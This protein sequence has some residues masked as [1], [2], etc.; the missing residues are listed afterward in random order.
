MIGLRHGTVELADHDPEWEHIAAET[1]H[2]LSRVLGS[3]AKDIQHVGSTAI[4][5]IKAKPIIDIAVAAEDF[6]EVEA[7]TPALEA[8]GFVYRKKEF[9]DTQLLYAC[10]DYS[11]PDG[12]VTR[13]IHVV[14]VDSREWSNY[15]NFRDYMNAHPEDARKYE[16]LKIRLAAENPIDS[17]REKYLAGKHDFIVEMLRIARIWN[18]FG[19]KFTKIEPLNKGWSS[20]KKYYIET[21][22]DERLLLRIADAKHCNVRQTNFEAMRRCF[23]AGVSMQE[24]LDFGECNGGKSVYTLLSYLDGEDAST[25]L[26]LLPEAEQYAMGLQAGE[27]LLKIHSI[28]APTDLEPWNVRFER[29]KLADRL[30]RFSQIP[31]KP[32]N[33]DVVLRYIAKNQHL[34]NGRPQTQCHND[35]DETNLIISPDG[36]IGAIDFGCGDGG[37]GDPWREFVSLRRGTSSNAVFHT[38]RVK[39]YF[40]GEPPV[41]FWQILSLYF[42]YDVI[43][44]ICNTYQYD[45]QGREDGLRHW[46]NVLSWYDNFNRVVPSW[47]LKDFYIPNTLMVY[48]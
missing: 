41:K 16:A 21:A 48:R 33:S 3:V 22:G 7:L 29:D 5:G 26:P 20:D 37:Y 43:A 45:E 31:V 18:D 9:E 39:A 12:I 8:A 23:A 24:P 46:R 14:N 10:G 38:A 4:R 15:L 17:G 11:K 34:V 47:Y 25:A 27:L 2:R 13:F 19:R 36:K 35:C 44:I 6:A 32:E 28:S 1:I 42:A 40:G 30:E